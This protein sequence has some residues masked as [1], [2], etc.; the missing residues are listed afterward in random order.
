MLL[1][2]IEM[3]EKLYAARY[4]STVK[5]VGGRKYLFILLFPL[6]SSLISATLVR[7]L[8]AAF[9]IVF[10]VSSI[11]QYN[12]ASILACIETTVPLMKKRKEAER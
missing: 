11:R 6:V 8:H 3:H 4:Q 10:I 5:N 9:A 12:D 7:P 2:F 1:H